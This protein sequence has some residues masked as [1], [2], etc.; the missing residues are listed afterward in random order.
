MEPEHIVTEGAEHVS[1]I[2]VVLKAEELFTVF[3]FPI[4]NSLLMTWLTM[5]ILIVFAVLFG[6]SLKLIPGKLQ[7]GIEWAFEGVLGYME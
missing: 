7:A 5:F 3:G 6:R 4:T 2:H 1:A